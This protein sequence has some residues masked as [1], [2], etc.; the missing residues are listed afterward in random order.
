MFKHI[1]VPIDGSELTPVT[2]LDAARLAHT[3]EAKI[4][5]LNVQAHYPP[6]LVGEIPAGSLRKEYEAQYASAAND[7]LNTAVAEVE[8]AGVKCERVVGM[9]HRPWEVIIR[10]AEADH[11][12]LIF[13]ASHGRKGLAGLL[14]GSETQK[15]L[16]HCTVPVIVHR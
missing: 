9:G 4:T 5:V 16:T 6:S 3:L 2:I 12:D 13:M 11:C 1:L 15:V 10:T 14:I 7:L 8:R